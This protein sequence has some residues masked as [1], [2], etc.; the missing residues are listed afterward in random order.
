MIRC[1]EC[2]VE[3]VLLSLI[4]SLKTKDCK[5]MP[6][7]FTV[8][9]PHRFSQNGDNFLICPRVHGCYPS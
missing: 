7:K 2:D 5:G 6:N 8:V 4:G 9:I 3:M 1:I